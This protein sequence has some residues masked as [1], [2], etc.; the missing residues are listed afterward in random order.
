MSETTDFLGR[1]ITPEDFLDKWEA[2]IDGNYALLSFNEFGDKYMAFLV[3]AIEPGKHEQIDYFVE[4]RDGK[5]V[6]DGDSQSWIMDM[7]KL[8]K[9]IIN[10]TNDLNR[11][12][13]MKAEFSLTPEGILWN[14]ISETR[15]NSILFK[16][17]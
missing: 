10:V 12:T 14:D 16:L 7:T 1:K 2:E 9:D 15:G 4:F 6:C 8:D 5:M 3:I 11:R 13:G 17:M